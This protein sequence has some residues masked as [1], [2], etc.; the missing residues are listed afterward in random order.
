MTYNVFS[1]TLNLAQLNIAFF[2]SFPLL[3]RNNRTCRP[4]FPWLMQYL[5]V[6][7]YKIEIDTYEK[8]SKNITVNSTSPLSRLYAAKR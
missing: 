3:C 1:G 5:G 8:C 6:V 4:T 2:S 7:C